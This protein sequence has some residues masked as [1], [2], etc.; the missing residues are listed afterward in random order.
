[1]AVDTWIFVE[2]EVEALRMYERHQ[3]AYQGLGRQSDGWPSFR[4]TASLERHVFHTAARCGV[5]VGEQ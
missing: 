5:G 2:A 3:D 4:L 1:M